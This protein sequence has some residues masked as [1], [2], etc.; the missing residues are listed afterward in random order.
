MCYCFLI[1]GLAIKE[2]IYPKNTAADIPPAEALTPPIKAPSK[3]CSCAPSIAPF[4]KLAPKPVKGTVAPHPAKS[5]TYLYIP[6]PPKTA[7]KVTKV[8]KIRA[9]VNLVLSI[10]I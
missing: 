5:I 4:A 8:T 10:K 9:G 1:F 3:P 7:P 2:A 6:S